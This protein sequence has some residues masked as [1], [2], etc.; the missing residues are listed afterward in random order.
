MNKVVVLDTS[1]NYF[2]IGNL[3]GI[4]DWYYTLIDVDVHDHAESI[5]GKELYIIES[6]QYGVRKNRNKAL[7]KKS[8]V[9]SI[10]L[11]SDVI[12]Y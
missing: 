3:A 12:D 8:E 7:V 1:A 4:D 10:S 9:I 5:S 6:K 2:F 11:L